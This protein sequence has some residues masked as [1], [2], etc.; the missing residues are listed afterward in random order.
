MLEVTHVCDIDP[1]FLKKYLQPVPVSIMPVLGDSG[2]TLILV[3][4]G[5]SDDTQEVTSLG[6]FLKWK[7]SGTIGMPVKKCIYG[8]LVL[9][10][11]VR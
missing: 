3:D 8:T 9:G 6:N 2:G 4:Y 11:K 1:F 10:V 7:F 5:V